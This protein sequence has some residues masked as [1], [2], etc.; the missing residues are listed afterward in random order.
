MYPSHVEKATTTFLPSAI[1]PFWVAGPSAMASPFLTFS[2]AFTIGFWLIQVP[3]FV[4]LN[5]RNLCTTVLPFL[6]LTVMLSPVTFSITPSS[7]ANTNIPE[8][9]AALYSIPVPTI[10]LSVIISGTAWRCMLAPIKALFA[11]SCSKNGIIAAA[12]ETNCFGDTST[13]WTL[14]LSTSITSF[15][16][17]TLILSLTNFPFL[18]TGSDA[19]AII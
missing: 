3:P 11:S 6:Y 8:S 1:S 4:L 19:W 13:Y 5:L 12:T 9:F 10:G 16:N 7:S 18:S 17:L 2:P 14:L 15:L